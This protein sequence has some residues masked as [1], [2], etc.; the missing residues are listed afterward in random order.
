MYWAGRARARRH[1]LRTASPR[2]PPES[3][4]DRR[5]VSGG[6]ASR[7]SNQARTNGTEAS[8]RFCMM[9]EGTWAGLAVQET[10][11]R[12]GLLA[13]VVTMGSE[14]ER[15]LVESLGNRSEARRVGKECV[16]TCRSRGGP[17]P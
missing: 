3:E 11:H 15:G 14:L 4:R 1:L 16:S 7:G 10:I 2:R 17:Y 8:P 5:S 6:P 9:H 13:K 12:E